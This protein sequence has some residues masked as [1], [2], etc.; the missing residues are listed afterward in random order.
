MSSP[1]CFLCGCVAAAR[2]DVSSTLCGMQPVP[3]T[4]HAVSGQAHFMTSAPLALRPC[5]LYAAAATAVIQGGDFERGNGTGGYSIYG[6]KFADEAFD[7]LH[8]PGVLSMANAGKNTN[9]SQ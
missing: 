4:K 6:R 7:V 3:H 5:L 8:A 1:G 9:G 2:G